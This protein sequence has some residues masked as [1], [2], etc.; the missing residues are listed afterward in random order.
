MTTL[1]D[2]KAPA[3]S[4]PKIGDNAAPR[5]GAVMPDGTIY[6]GASP[7]TGNTTREVR[8]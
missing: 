1:A 4:E 8:P 7:D 3:S 5:M 2:S 6:A